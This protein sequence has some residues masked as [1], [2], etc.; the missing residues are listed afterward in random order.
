VA[1]FS[2]SDKGKLA[3]VL[4]T[5]PEEVFTVL[6]ESEPAVALVVIT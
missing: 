3:E 2:D 4:C 1:D 6:L 5:K